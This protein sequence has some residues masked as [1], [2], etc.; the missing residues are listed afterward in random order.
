MKMTSRTRLSLRINNVSFVLLLLAIMALLAWLSTQYVYQADWTQNARHTLTAPSQAVLKQLPQS[1]QITAYIE[2]DEMSRKLISDL[3]RKYQREKPDID[4]RFID[5]Y[6]VPDKIKALNLKMTPQGE[7]FAALEFNYDGRTEHIQQLIQFLTEQELS[8]ALQRLARNQ[9]HKIAFLQGHGERNPRGQANHDLSLWTQELQNTGLEVHTLNLSQQTAIP[10]D[11]RALIIA[12]P[13]VNLL[14]GEAQVIADY[15]QQGG[16]V[17]WM[18]EPNEPLYGLD[19]VAAIFNLTITPG[20]LVDPVSLVGSNNPGMVVLPAYSHITPHVIVAGFQQDTLFPNVTALY[21]EPP[22][23]WDIS[24]VLTTVPDVWSEISELKGE[25]RFDEGQDIDGALAVGIALSRDIDSIQQRV[26]ILGDGDFISNTFIGNGGNL[27][28][29]LRIMN[30]LIQDDSF[31][32]IP[33]QT[34]DETKFN[35]S[36]ET[37]NLLAFF[38]VIVLPVSLLIIGMWIWLKRRKA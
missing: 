33:L 22:E 34:T 9:K 30:W 6:T 13:Q 5:P 32:D 7:L 11:I 37:F 38:F 18:L 15:V 24:N 36:S 28:L 25:I 27:E 16:N 2:D 14:D 12:S 31:I 3:I 35:L 23:D 21:A 4:L 8:S 19:P 1:I 10:D 26:M 29:S 20:V 17:L